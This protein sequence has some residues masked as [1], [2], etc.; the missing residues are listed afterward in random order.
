MTT[1]AGNHDLSIHLV[2][3]ICE[4]ECFLL[5]THRG[6]QG[7]LSALCGVLSRFDEAKKDRDIRFV[8]EVTKFLREIRKTIQRAGATGVPVKSNLSERIQ[9]VRNM[10]RDTAKR[11]IIWRDG[12]RVPDE[13][14]VFRMQN[15]GIPQRGRPPKEG[16]VS[17]QMMLDLW[18]ANA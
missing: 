8:P 18:G 16:R 13:N 6:T 3:V 1:L 4:Y 11:R 14:L 15:N 9:W 5:S 7:D 10:K 12:A 17:V 2:D